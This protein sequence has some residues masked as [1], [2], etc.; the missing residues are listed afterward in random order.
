M[1]YLGE[2]QTAKTRSRRPEGHTDACA[3]WQ[4][5]GHSVAWG[6]QRLWWPAAQAGSLGHPSA[7]TSQFQRARGGDKCAIQGG[8][9]VG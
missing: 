4:R 8:V 9:C 2:G 5:P 7:S 3:G 1:L 6:V